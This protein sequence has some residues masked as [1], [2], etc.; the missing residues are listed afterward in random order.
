[1]S[2]NSGKRN[3]LGICRSESWIYLFL[4]LF[5][6]RKEGKKQPLEEIGRLRPPSLISFLLLTVE[7]L[8]DQI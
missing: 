8:V 6:L 5:L 1:M 4:L 3:F 7:Y 2:E